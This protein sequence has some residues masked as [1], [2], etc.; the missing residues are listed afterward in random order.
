MYPEEIAYT[1]RHRY[2]VTDEQWEQIKG[3]FPLY[4]TEHPSFHAIVVNVM[5]VPFYWKKHPLTHLLW[6]EKGRKL[7]I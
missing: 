2:E 5:I 6:R 3:F 4:K 7:S 1:S